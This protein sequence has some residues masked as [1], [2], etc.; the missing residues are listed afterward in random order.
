MRSKLLLRE[1]SECGWIQTWSQTWSIVCLKANICAI[2][3]LY[4]LVKITKFQSTYSQFT[5]QVSDAIK[6]LSTSR[7][8]LTRH[9]YPRGDPGVQ[10]TALQES[11]ASPGLPTMYGVRVT[12]SGS[13]HQPACGDCDAIHLPKIQLQWDTVTTPGR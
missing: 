5:Y 11:S 3:P 8:N 2:N 13:L 6:I 12:A 10:H 7:S 4:H 9:P 1:E